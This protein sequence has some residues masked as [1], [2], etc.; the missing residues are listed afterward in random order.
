[1]KERTAA[2]NMIVEILFQTEIKQKKI[3]SELSCLYL[4]HIIRKD[5]VNGVRDVVV[6]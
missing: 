4:K 1:M 2:N 3:D 6:G 5:I